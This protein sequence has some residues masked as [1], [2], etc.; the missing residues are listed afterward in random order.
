MTLPELLKQAEGLLNFRFERTSQ[1]DFVYYMVTNRSPRVDVYQRE[2]QLVGPSRYEHL[3]TMY[4]PMDLPI[5]ACD[6]W[7]LSPREA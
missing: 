4:D 6:D 1:P 3:F 7:I 2:R 5:A